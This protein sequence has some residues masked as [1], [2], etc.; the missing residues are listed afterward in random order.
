MF[1]R[2]HLLILDPSTQAIGVLFS[3]LSPVPM[4]SRLFLTLCPI[5]FSHSSFMLRSLI[6]LDLSFEQGDRYGFICILLYS[7]TNLDQHHLLKMLSLFH[8]M[9]LASLSKTK[10]L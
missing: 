4:S 7:D 6:H 1:I 10:C 3:K 8:Y 5:R 2:C 9:V